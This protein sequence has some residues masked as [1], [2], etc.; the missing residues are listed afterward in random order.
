MQLNKEQI[1][2]VNFV[3]GNLL[4]VA[5]AGTGKT[6][7]IVERY[8]NMIQNHG[9]KPSEIMM[10]T[11]TNK[12]AKDMMKKII[13]RTGSEPPYIGTMHSLF[14]KILR[15]NIKSTSLKDDFTLIDDNADKRKIVKNILS[16]ERI[17]TKGDNIKYFVNWIGKFKNRGIWSGYF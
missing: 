14:L 10:T 12:A 1:E 5:S 9:Y 11:F 6:T 13:E 8:A 4:I 15:D 17:D 2:A 16:L 7:T 3:S